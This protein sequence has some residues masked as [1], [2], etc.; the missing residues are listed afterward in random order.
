MKFYN[1]LEAASGFRLHPAKYAVFLAAATMLPAAYAEED[2]SKE[3]PFYVN[4]NT[5][6]VAPEAD[7]EK[8]GPVTPVSEGVWG[9]EFP[10]GYQLY[11]LQGQRINDSRWD[12]PGVSG[13]LP[14]MTRWGMIVMR[15]GNPAPDHYT[16]VK[17]D[18]SEVQCPPEYIYPTMFVDSLA[19]V[20]IREGYKIKYRYI[21]PDLKI[22]FPHLS[23]VSE[24]FE[25]QNAT[26]PP[27]SEELRAYCTDVD[28]YKL[29]GYID[30]NGKV[31]IEP[32]FREARSFHCGRA[33]VKDKNG[34]QFFIDNKGVKAFEPAWGD[35]DDVSD[36]D[37]N[38]CAAPG[39]RYDET[40][41][42]DLHGQKITT[43]KNGT[44]FHNGYAY[45][46]VFHDELNR[47]LIHRV[48]KNFNVL[49]AIGVTTSDFNPP[50][51]DELDVAHF[52]PWAVDGAKCNPAYIH[53]YTIGYF[54]K[55]GYAPATMWTKDG[56]T[57]YKGFIDT[58]G[59][60]KLLYQTITKKRP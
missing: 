5:I 24:R 39:S 22:A 6:K 30:R 9:R 12:L 15:G 37:S 1:L 52:K 57:S 45:C 56:M 7:D 8:G 17:P 48:D 26:T 10:D 53:D 60:F 23:P 58:K 31:V 34:K 49:E 21:T 46:Y 20:G 27:L 3:E 13:V 40:D 29:W 47:N 50:G 33:L 54:S 28:G 36:Y 14:R 38:I 11:N 44:P 25:G 51:Y 32:Q 42:Y 2:L 55:E 16:L 19:I 18:G 41:Y 35:Y 4:E 43:L 59:H